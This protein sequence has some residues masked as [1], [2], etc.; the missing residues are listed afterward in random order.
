M[1]V[2]VAK[3]DYFK[4][5]MCHSPTSMQIYDTKGYLK[6]FN[7]AFES[8]FEVKGDELLGK[9]NILEDR[10][11][12]VLG[13][14]DYLHRT[15]NGESFDNIVTKY[16]ASDVNG[17]ERWLRTAIFPIKS[18]H[19]EVLDFAVMHE[20]ITDLKNNELHLE[21][22]IAERTSALEK[23][24]KELES[25]AHIDALTTLNNRRVFDI[26][27]EKEYSLAKRLENPLSLILIDVDN[28]KDY[29]D[30][31]GHRRGDVCLQKV[32][33]CIKSNAQRG[34]DTAV[35]YGGEEFAII[36]PNTR[37]ADLLLIAEKIRRAVELLAIPHESSDHKR[38]TISLGV[39]TLRMGDDL[40]LE[41]FFEETDR[42][43]Y[44]AKR[45]GKNKL[46]T[47]CHRF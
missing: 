9:Y 15:I 21:N 16:D 39:G 19:G 6:E 1:T 7:F 10:Q 32:A 43:L 20:D 18:D 46:V 34:S 25:M 28:F 37:K 30:L 29:N 45:T 26:V 2:A 13:V 11:L 12:E 4:S 17:R 35:R 24:N 31:Y 22:I 3:D 14:M 38:V 47:M 42:A 27:F 44:Q 36:L 40:T 8:L 33:M 5:I 23:L 41:S